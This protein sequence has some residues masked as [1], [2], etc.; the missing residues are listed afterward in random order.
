VVFDSPEVR[1]LGPDPDGVLLD[2]VFTLRA[3]LVYRLR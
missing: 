1:D 2:W 3:G